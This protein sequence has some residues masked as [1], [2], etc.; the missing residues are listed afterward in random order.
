MSAVHRIGEW[1]LRRRLGRGGMGAVYLAESAAGERAALKQ[2]PRPAEGGAEPGG[3]GDPLAAEAKLLAS[4]VHPNIVNLREVI[5]TDA[6]CYLILELVDGA[7]LRDRMRGSPLP[8][9]EGFS[10]MAGVLSALDHAHRHSVVHLDVKPENVLIS[11]S[12]EVKVTDFG[13]ASWPRRSGPAGLPTTFGTPQYMSP[14]QARGGPVDARSDLY[15]AGVLCYEIFCGRPPFAARRGFSPAVLAAQHVQSEP[16]AP[17]AIRPGFDAELESVIM[18]SLAKQAG[19][20]YQSA[21]AFRDALNRVAERLVGPDPGRSG[22]PSSRLQV[23]DGGW[24]GEL[25]RLFAPG[26]ESPASR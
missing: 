17:S 26:P 16:P 10:V 6:G 25:R 20:R 19:D 24:L 5:R 22:S 23:K 9:S 8:A 18:K 4:L 13:I 12:G 3:H 7:S 11:H 15:S 14:E 1:R 2:L 21:R